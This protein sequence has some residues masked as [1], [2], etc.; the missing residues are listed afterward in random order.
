VVTLDRAFRVVAFAGVTRATSQPA[1]AWRSALQ[2]AQRST[3]WNGSSASSMSMVSRNR[4]RASC[5]SRFLRASICCQVITAAGAG[6]T[7]EPRLAV[8]RALE[9]RL[10]GHQMHVDAVDLAELAGPDRA[11]MEAVN[12][13]VVVFCPAL[14]L[15]EVRVTERDDRAARGFG[16]DRFAVPLR[17]WIS[18]QPAKQVEDE[19]RVR[20]L[21]RLVLDAPAQRRRRTGCVS[22]RVAHRH[23]IADAAGS[24]R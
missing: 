14:D 9:P 20:M 8:P 13:G 6:L 21:A 3:K 16:A 12:V 4:P 18:R 22:C 5:S 11:R 19:D 2:Y 17:A 23:P 7:A 10:V 24:P 15:L 1:M